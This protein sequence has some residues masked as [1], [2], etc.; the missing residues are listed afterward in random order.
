MNE[1]LSNKIIE[2]RKVIKEFYDKLD[3]KVWISFS[4][5]KDSTVLLHLV[6]SIYPDV[7]GVFSDTGLEFPEIKQ[8]VKK[9]DNIEIVKPSRKFYDIVKDYGIPYPSKEVTTKVHEIQHST[10]HI[11]NIRKNGYPNG[12]G[13]LSKKWYRLI[14]YEKVHNIKVQSKCCYHLKKAPFTK[15]IN[16]NKSYPFIG[17]T[18]GES[19]LRLTSFK[20]FGFNIFNGSKSQSRPI[21]LFSDKDIWDYIEYY[22]LNYSKI[23]DIGYSRTGCMFCLFGIHLEKGSENRLQKMKRTHPNQWRYVIYNLDYKNLL[24]LEGIPYNEQRTLW[25]YSNKN[26]SFMKKGFSKL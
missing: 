19:S 15:Y 23:Y 4:G 7:K 11:K 26:N 20:R 25:N 16:K 21:S 9:V 5:G 2:A 6:R 24:D 18:V 13:K 1:T 12:H 3:G 8:F 14:T 10:D 22:N 17:T